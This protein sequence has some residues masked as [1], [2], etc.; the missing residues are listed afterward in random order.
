VTSKQLSSRQ[1]VP[2]ELLCVVQ[3]LGK[4]ACRYTGRDIHKFSADERQTKICPF[5]RTR[6]VDLTAQFPETVSLTL[7]A[8]LGSLHFAQISR[9]ML[10]HFSAFLFKCRTI[11][12]VDTVCSLHDNWYY[13]KEFASRVVW[14][15]SLPLAT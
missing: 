1:T 14:F 3:K 15:K 7:S 12:C 9:V 2:A 11:V 5:M 6:L 8:K 4:V 13:E 10:T